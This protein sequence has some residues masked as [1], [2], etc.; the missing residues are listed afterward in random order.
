M[1]VKVKVGYLDRAGLHKKG[2]IVEV[3]SLD[4]NLHG[5]IVEEKKVE[6]K[7]PKASAKKK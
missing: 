1:K 7:K 2:D 6:E 3:K 5:E 4:P